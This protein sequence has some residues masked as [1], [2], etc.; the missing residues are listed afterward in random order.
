VYDPLTDTWEY[1]TPVPTPRGFLAS[2]V[3]NDTIYAIGGGY[4]TSK[5]VVEAY[6]PATDTWTTKAKMLQPRIGMA[7]AVVN[8]IIY[9]IGGNYTER[10]CQAYDP[11]TNT[12]EEKTPVPVG[13][14]GV[15]SATVY[16]GLIYVF[17][18][19]D[20]SGVP[21]NAVYAYD[22]QTDTW[23]KKTD[24]ITGRF[25]LQTYLVDGRIYVIGGSQAQYTAVAT[26]EVYD[27]VNNTWNTLANMPQSCAVFAGAVVNGRVYVLGG[28]S[29]W[30]TARTDVW[31]F[32]PLGTPT[33]IDRQRDA[34]PTS[35]LLEQNYPNPFNPTTVVSYQLPVVSDVKLAVYDLLGR[36]VT[37]LVDEK[38]PAGR[39]EF[40]FDATGLSSGVYVYRLT[41]GEYV[42]S[43]R[44]VL[45]R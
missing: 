30:A 31:E 8:G 28:T 41:T 14:G 16:N 26:V 24:M 39:Y 21:Y 19:S 44:M 9:I 36:E 27:P 37:V 45:I 22:P 3:V 20:Y 2:A 23:T 38:K 33:G 10:N 32:D 1:R 15:V 29:D 18:G 43:R 25:A 4:P 12:W 17:G 6:D 35:F 42:E 7:A 13:S 40:R 11:S 5:D 34:L